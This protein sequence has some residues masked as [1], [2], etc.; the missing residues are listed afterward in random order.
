MT[1]LFKPSAPWKIKVS[2]SSPT[3]AY[4]LLTPFGIAETIPGKGKGIWPASLQAIMP[5]NSAESPH[6]QRQCEIVQ[7]FLT[8]LC[9][10]R[11]RSQ[12]MC[13]D[14][15]ASI[16]QTL[17]PFHMSNALEMN[18]LLRH[19]LARILST[20]VEIVDSKA[21]VI[22][23]PGRTRNNVDGERLVGSINVLGLMTMTN[24]DMMHIIL[25][26]QIEI[27][28]THAVGKGPVCVSLVLSEFKREMMMR[29]NDLFLCMMGGFELILKPSPLCSGVALKLSEIAD[30]GD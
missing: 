27:P 6:S 15:G 29:D 2:S 21:V 11:L 1:V 5:I 28:A 23:E 22:E 16:G 25:L 17:R 3:W 8:G 12:S 14:I 13:E 7:R 24:K 20:D 18:I 9:N 30:Q 4:F 26:D 19:I 10:T